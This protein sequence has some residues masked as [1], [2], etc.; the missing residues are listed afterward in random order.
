M[1][2]G[3]F[4]KK[5]WF[6][7]ASFKGKVRPDWI[8]MRVAPL[9]RPWKGHQPLYVF[10]FLISLLNRYVKRLQSS[11]PLHTKMNPTS[12]LFGSWFVKN[13]FLPIG[14]RTFIWWKNPPMCWTILVWIATK[15]LWWYKVTINYSC[16]LS[17]M[18][19]TVYN[20]CNTWR[21]AQ[22]AD[23]PFLSPECSVG[24][25]LHTMQLLFVN[26][27]PKTIEFQFSKIC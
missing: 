25:I 2:A 24:N 22:W 9:D 11:E 5:I 26:W 8:C 16:T 20:W 21:L 17:S 23:S 7:L 10:N 15:S 14:W 13:P 4:K 1:P 27:S 3:K 18:Y 6:F 19:S 12:C